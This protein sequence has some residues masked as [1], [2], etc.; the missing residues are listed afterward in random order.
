MPSTLDP[1]SVRQTS[2]YSL[3]KHQA[4]QH[5]ESIAF[6]APSRTP[7]TYQGLV[8]QI[9]V[10]VK[11]LNAMQLGRNDRVAIVLPGGVDLAVAV[12]CVAAGATCA[13]LNPQYT[14]QE[15]E[16][17]L[18]DVKARAVIVA[19]ENESS[20]V[21]VARAQGIAVIELKP[22]LTEAAG[23][24][25]LVYESHGTAAKPILAE[26][27]DVAIVLHTSGTTARPKLV[28][29]SQS[30]I[31]SSAFHSRDAF[32]L[33]QQDRCLN[34]M[35]LF[36]V[37]GL[38]SA[39]LATLAGGGT[40]ICPP[41]F[42]TRQF[43]DWIAEFK[44]TWYTASPTMHQAILGQSSEHLSVID[45]YPLRFVRSSS[46][47]LPPKLMTALEQTF[48]AP[49]IEYYGMTEAASQITSNPMPPQE[50]KIG[51]AGIAAGPH[52][53]IVDA[54]NKKVLETGKIGEIV[55][56]GANVITGYEDNPDANAQAFVDGWF[57]SGDLGYFDEDGYL[58]ITGRLKELINRGGE[59]ISPREV[60]EVLM[61][62][63]S[64]LLAVSFAMPHATLGEDIV[65]AVT[66]HPQTTVSVRELRQFAFTRLADY[67]VPSQIL[68]VDELP[69]GPTGKPQRAGL[70]EKFAHQLT[71][72]YVAA[73]N[74]IEQAIIDIWLDILDV[75]RIGVHDNFFLLGGDSLLAT[76]VIARVRSLF[77][78]AL[79]LDSIFREPTVAGF[80]LL[81]EEQ[82][83]TEI[84]VPTSQ[85]TASSAVE[86][87]VAQQA[88]AS[89]Y[90]LP[91][92]LTV[93]HQNRLETNHFFREIFEGGL[94]FKHG[95]TLEPACV[96]FDV[97]ANIGLFSLYVHQTYGRINLFA[98]EPVPQL[99]GL[100]QA[101]M[102]LHDIDTQL[103][104]S[105]V[106]STLGKALIRYYPNNSGMST[107][108]PNEQ[109]EQLTLSTI[110]KNRAESGSL[111]GERLSSYTDEL[112][113]E[114]FQY[115]EIECQVQTISDVM[116]AHALTTIDLLK[117]DAQKS[118]LDI[119][120]GIR[121]EDWPK[122]RQLVLEVH[123]IEGR[124]AH[125]RELLEQQGYA[126][127]MDQDT[128]VKGSILY[129][130][131][132]RR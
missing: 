18:T 2:V 24:F 96:V 35:P 108:Y 116:H 81:L 99:F 65:A 45:T 44:P 75:E 132:A 40:V 83:A 21:E 52:V 84:V 130:L 59:K 100:L 41:Q 88:D 54:N 53:Q 15:F 55:L 103:F 5:P 38:I 36:H 22:A 47:P 74:E 48:H 56:R 57:R 120:L 64:V 39:S 68:I 3:L 66:L 107:L 118:E 126:V 86:P 111:S 14:K 90:V 113:Q 112:F 106:S 85:V 16:F 104:N 115:Q 101:N 60:D 71:S 6:T 79:S 42:D 7:V 91:N 127:A 131:Y 20:V 105:A 62:H 76:M 13:P 97:G 93:L 46:S 89:S 129:Y 125:I 82:L 10:V 34:I 128:E 26:P 114:R 98:F 4:E 123:D 87:G 12:F 30:N 78:T 63:P 8:Q 19:S 77:S 102:S 109:E 32:Q 95:I 11:T 23:T 61:E 121:Q 117:I 92:G 67:K 119:I 70:A 94:Y 122:I 43:F 28:P 27:D 72:D 29:L 73:A 69:K 37:H 58:F 49:V 25:S 110:L 50:R 33:S 51:S 9:E 31:C 1:M 80:A 17:Y 124:L